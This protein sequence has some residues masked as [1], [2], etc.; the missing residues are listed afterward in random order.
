ML[1]AAMQAKAE[2]SGRCRTG[3]RRRIKETSQFNNVA[4]P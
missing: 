4:A 2:N 3:I 1:D